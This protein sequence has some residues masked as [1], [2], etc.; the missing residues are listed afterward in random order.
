M[1]E[2]MDII[3]KL[4]LFQEIKFL[5]TTSFCLYRFAGT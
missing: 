4:F 2:N 3:I 5:D 1:S